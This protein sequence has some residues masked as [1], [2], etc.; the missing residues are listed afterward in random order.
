MKTKDE[1]ATL[2]A[3]YEMVI[4][5]FLMPLRR[6]IVRIAM[7]HRFTNILDLCCGTGRQCIMLDAAG[8]RVAGVD[9]SP[10]MLGEA[11]A[12][13]PP[14]IEYFLEDAS[15]LHFDDSSFE[16]VILCFAL[17]EKTKTIRDEVMK[18]A[19]RV[20]TAAGRLITV[21]YAVPQGF[22]EICIALP[23]AGVERIAGHEHYAAYRDFMRC[24]ALD[25]VLSEHGLAIEQKTRFLWGTAAL[26]V[27]TKRKHSI[28]R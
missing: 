27:S 14:S 4:G 18:E 21:D 19:K 9:N 1:Y 22:L 11:L 28:T 15:A 24:G 25:A 16:C 3:Y 17:H 8:F 6:E 7:R 5:P 10:S 2:A 13:S 23:A 12:G 26:V 20:L